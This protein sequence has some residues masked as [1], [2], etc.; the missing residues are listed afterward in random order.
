MYFGAKPFRFPDLSGHESPDRL[1]R[2]RCFGPSARGSAFRIVSCLVCPHRLTVRRAPADL[3]ALPRR[4]RPFSDASSP[5]ITW[6]P[7]G[8]G[9]RDRR[10]RRRLPVAPRALALPPISPAEATVHPLCRAGMFPRSATRLVV[11][12]APCSAASPGSHHTRADGLFGPVRRRR[13]S[14]G[15]SWRQHAFRQRPSPPK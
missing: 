1:G 5:P 6:D 7:P 15:C 9:L 8:A 13:G 12:R 11:R 10:V 3:I 14:C 4:S 2:P